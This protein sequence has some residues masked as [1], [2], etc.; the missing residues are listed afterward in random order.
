MIEPDYVTYMPQVASTG[1]RPIPVPL[2]FD[3]E[4][5]F[6]IE[7]LEK[8]ANP[9]VKLLMMSNADN[10]GG[11]HYTEED[12]KAIAELAEKY[13][14]MVLSDQVSEEFILEPEKSKYHS[15]ASIPGME[16][17]TIISGSHSKMYGLGPLRTGW[18]VSNKDFIEN[19][20]WFLMWV[21][22]GVV[23]S[24]VDASLAIL[25]GGNET[26]TW[27]K[28][29]NERLRKRRDHMNKR[30]AE[31]E[32]VIPNTAQG[33]YW[34]FP[35]VGSFGM[36]SHRLAEYLLKEVNLFVRPGT[37]YGHTGEGHFRLLFAIPE[38]WI[39]EAMDRMHKG[40]SKLPVVSKELPNK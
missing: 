19:L 5:R 1:A 25:Q 17:R 6:E 11:F 14:F 39:D 37:W 16:E 13:D 40:L 32:G 34:A 15:I 30:L 7:E 18:V 38:D 9:M 12:N 22:D 36:S 31:I 23:G 4:W 24:A 28:T 27:V 3:G 20:Y 8:R 21:N 35:W 33:I 29:V 2:H 26:E 10:P